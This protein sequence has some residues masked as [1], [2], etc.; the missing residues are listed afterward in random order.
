MS[1]HVMGD[2]AVR[3]AIVAAVSFLVVMGV[4]VAVYVLCP[5]GAPVVVSAREVASRDEEAPAQGFEHVLL[6]EDYQFT[7]ALPPLGDRSVTYEYTITLKVARSHREMLIDLIDPGRRNMLS[8]VKESI[9]RIIGREDYLKL[10]SEQLQDVKRR[11]ADD[12][13]ARMHAD[14]VQDVIFDKWNVIP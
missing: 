7:K 6:L 13:N 1:E 9:R 5:W 3:A 10:R 2:F 11:I 14:V 8:V 12:L 4:V